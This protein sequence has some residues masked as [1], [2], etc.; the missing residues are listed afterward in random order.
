[1]ITI[2]QVSLICQSAI[3]LGLIFVLFFRLWPAHRLDSFRQNMFALRDEVFD[4]A[5]SGKIGFD[6]PSYK[7]LRQSMNGFIRYAH[8]LTFYRL[9]LTILQ[10]RV[11]QDEPE[12][13]WAKSW[14]RSLKTLP[15]GV[16][17]ELKAFHSRAMMLAIERLVTGSVILMG[18]LAI[19]ILVGAV[20]VGWKNFKTLCYEKASRTVSRLIDPRLLEEDAVRMAA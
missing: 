4:Y 1:M 19:I 5:A 18:V 7:L 6:H 14:D 20:H 15:K 12:L 9:C 11:L 13:I 2:A 8:R 10:W 16:Q 3:A 17:A